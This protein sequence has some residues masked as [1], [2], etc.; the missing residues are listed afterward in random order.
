MTV[1]VVGHVE[2]ITFLRV[3]GPVEPGAIVTA[4][5]EWSEAAGG[6]G[7]AAAELARLAGRATLFTALGDDPVGQGIP[8]ALAPLGVE[9]R[10]VARAGEPHRRGITLVDPQRERTIVVIGDAQSLRGSDAVDLGT[11][12]A[13]YFCKGDAAM[14]RAARRSARVLVA[15]ARVLPI[16]REAGVELDALVHSASDPSERYAPGDLD[17]AP[18]LVATTEGEAG[19]RFRLVHGREGRWAAAPPPARLEDSYGAGDSFAA[20]LAFALAEGRSPEDALAFAAARGAAAL[21]RRGAHR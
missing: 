5:E 1:G 13:V 18:K 16:L 10:A 19:G 6:G 4:T 3:D 11:L 17:P 8:A 9:V 14:V 15:T 2:W 21:G 12:D 20:G 7:V